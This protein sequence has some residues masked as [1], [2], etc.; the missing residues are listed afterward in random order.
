MQS[1]SDILKSSAGFGGINV[2]SS[3]TL[4][5]LFA[6]GDGKTFFACL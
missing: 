4:L 5:L 3:I 2:L 1:G 6:G